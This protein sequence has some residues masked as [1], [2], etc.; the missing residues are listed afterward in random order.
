MRKLIL[1]FMVLPLLG[2]A[3]NKNLMSV[4]RYFPKT[5]KAAMFEKA[6][7]AH[8]Q[9]YHKG[10]H[11]WRVYSIETGPDAGGYQVVEGPTNWTGIDN[12]GDLGDAHTKDWQ[13]TVQPH[14]ED[15]FSFMYVSFREDL[16]TVALGDFSDKISITHLYYKPG[17]YGVMLAN[18]RAQK[19]LWESDGYSMAV[20]EA[21]LS[22][23]PRFIIVSRYKNGL[24][25]RDVQKADPYDVRFTK[26][27]GADG[28]STW[29]KNYKEGLNSTSSEIL[30][31]KPLLGSQQ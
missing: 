22:G 1:L 2:I 17:Y 6:L 21:T 15:K 28:W 4:D 12:R 27:N 19:K 9:K 29:L 23:E 8:A 25:D 16:S 7:A 3:Q 10:D 14:V 26:V 30:Y 31:L 24:K 13:T 20:Y 5:G 11:S 18:I